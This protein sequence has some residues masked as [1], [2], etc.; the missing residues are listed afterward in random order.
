VRRGENECSSEIAAAEGELVFYSIGNR[1]DFLP[2]R[3][4]MLADQRRARF[5][6]PD[7]GK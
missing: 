1:R 3:P 7:L 5:D 6:A 4:I 2:L